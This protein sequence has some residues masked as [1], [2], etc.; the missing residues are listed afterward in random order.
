MDGKEL[1]PLRK[2]SEA[3]QREIIDFICE[4]AADGAS[5]KKI[6]AALAEKGIGL[7][8]V[9]IGYKLRNN[10]L[11]K[12]TFNK[13]T[14][15]LE[16][17]LNFFWIA[18]KPERIKKYQ[19]IYNEAVAS[20]DYATAK[21]VLKTVAKELGQIVEKSEAVHRLRDDTTRVSFGDEEDAPWFAPDKDKK[22]KELVN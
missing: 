7:S 22:K 15:A 18:R 17:S 5:Y 20:Q 3:Q 8:G 13:K 10:K 6:S 14:F 19:E 16:D 4:A 1:I 11:W 12:E 2:L 9:T 21:D